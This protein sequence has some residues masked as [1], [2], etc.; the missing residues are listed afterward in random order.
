MDK[1]MKQTSV[2]QRVLTGA[3]ALL[4]TLT[5]FAGVGG[6][7]AA[8]IDSG[9]GSAIVEESRGGVSVQAFTQDFLSNELEGDASLLGAE[10]TVYD[11]DGKEVCV[12]ATNEEGFAA[13]GAT[14]L[15]V[16]TYSIKQTKAS[17]GY[18]LNSVWE[19]EFEI[20]DDAQVINLTDGYRWTD[21]FDFTSN[22]PTDFRGAANEIIRG[23][24]R[25]YA[26]TKDRSETGNTSDDNL[27]EGDAD[28]AG[29]EFRTCYGQWS[30]VPARQGCSDYL[31]Q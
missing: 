28:L 18:R 15:P 25:I 29:A 19:K 16:G 2:G 10:F 8:D 30:E 17:E 3:L 31:V 26:S 5:S 20:K 24:L 11:A 7:M 12:I 14:A 1:M 22:D 13:T 27:G 23:G 9:D 4:M 6:T 21:A